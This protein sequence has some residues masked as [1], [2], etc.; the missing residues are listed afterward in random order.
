MYKIRPFIEKIPETFLHYYDPA[1]EQSIDESMVK[2]KGR[3]TV[4]QY[5]P[6]K[7]MKNKNYH[8][9]FDNYFTSND[10]MITLL[11]DGISACRT[12]RKDRKGL[13]KNQGKEKDMKMRNSEYRTSYEG[14]TWLE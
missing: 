6:Q 14:I 2:F 11:K 4:K 9:Y 3:S 7:P 12:I 10:L 5:L 13:P 8:I 1:R